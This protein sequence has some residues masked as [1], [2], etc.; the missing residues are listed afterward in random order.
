MIFKD[1]HNKIRSFIATAIVP[2]MLLCACNSQPDTTASSETESSV[3]SASDTSDNTVTTATAS[4]AAE[5]TET[6]ETAETAETLDTSD[7]SASAS[8][9]K[10]ATSIEE[11]SSGNSMITDIGYGSYGF[12]MGDL[13]LHSQNDISMMIQP[14]DATVYDFGVRECSWIDAFYI[15]E[16]FDMNVFDS[17]YR[18][19]G[20]YNDDTSINFD[21]GSKIGTW[22]TPKGSD[23][24]L[25][26]TEITIISHN[27][28]IKILPEHP[29]VASYYN[30]SV[31]GRGYYVS[32]EQL[33]MADFFLSYLAEN[34]GVDPL[35]GLVSSVNHT[36]YF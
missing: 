12:M 1:N 3:T 9:E 23:L 20:F 30:V 27:L 26:T 16:S 10:T 15:Q 29:S 18:F 7:A 14:E 36:Y 28:E 25:Y 13:R 21:P 8:T 32:E 19:L 22:T 17:S 2:G 31:C 35:E 5:T 33:Q 34:P 4:S 6:T 24:E 11:T